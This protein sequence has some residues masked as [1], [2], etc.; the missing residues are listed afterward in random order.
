MEMRRGLVLGYGDWDW[1]WGLDIGIED[2]DL[3]LGDWGLGFGIEIGVRIK[4]TQKYSWICGFTKCPWS[5]INFILFERATLIY[6]L[7]LY[8]IYTNFGS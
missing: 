3:I 1:G 8:N 7:K 2:W 6:D 5:I 4:K